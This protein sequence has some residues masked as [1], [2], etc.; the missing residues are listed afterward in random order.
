M[1]NFWMQINF[2]IGFAKIWLT[3]SKSIENGMGTILFK[4]P[5]N[6]LFYIPNEWNYILT[7]GKWI[8][9][10]IYILMLFKFFNDHCK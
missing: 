10:N 5:E 8:L 6:Y 9:H 2:I 4:F 3:V 7:K 1:S